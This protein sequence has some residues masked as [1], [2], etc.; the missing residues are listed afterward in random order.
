MHNRK[1][2]VFHSNRCWRVWKFLWEDLELILHRIFITY[3]L[4]LRNRLNKI[5]IA[6]KSHSIICR[7]FIQML[8][9]LLWLFMFFFCK[10]YI[11]FKIFL[12]TCNFLYYSWNDLKK[13]WWINED[14]FSRI[15]LS[16]LLKNILL[17]F[18]K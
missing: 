8:W 3:S 10:L 9:T 18:K 1:T 5:C 15:M 14:N 12:C 2:V 6:K 16:N 13:K 7:I 4:T 17:Y 11:I